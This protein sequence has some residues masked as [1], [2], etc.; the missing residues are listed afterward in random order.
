MHKIL[1]VEPDKIISN[2][3]F[4]LFSKNG[5]NVKESS[6]AN[7]AIKLVDQYRPDVLILE[8]Q[9]VE[10]SGIELLYE[11]RSYTDLDNL[12]VII[13]SNIPYSEF[14]NTKFNLK[15]ELDI[16]NYFYKPET[17]LSKLL[18]MVNNLNIQYV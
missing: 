3:Y 13:L 10:H 8:L 7:Q 17:K 16:E 15:K 9:L 6:N 2:I 12:R 14:Q 18:E 4:E 5:H 1:I 11:I